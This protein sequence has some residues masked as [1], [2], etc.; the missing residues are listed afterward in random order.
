M[1]HDQTPVATVTVNERDALSYYPYVQGGPVEAAYLTIEGLELVAYVNSRYSELDDA[2]INARASAL[3]E[4]AGV[5]MWGGAIKG[6]ALLVLG[7]GNGH[8]E[9]SLPPE[10]ISIFTNSDAAR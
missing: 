3:F 8:Y 7:A 9:R 2:M 4:M 6:D 10:I 1:P 5:G